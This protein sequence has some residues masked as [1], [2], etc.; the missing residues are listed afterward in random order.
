MV[1]S[2][3]IQ[4]SIQGQCVHVGCSVCPSSVKHAHL[5]Q[6]CLG[7]LAAVLTVTRPVLIL[8]TQIILK[9]YR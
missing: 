1:V 6:S 7:D 8:L 3:V 5:V 4:W 2:G 9:S